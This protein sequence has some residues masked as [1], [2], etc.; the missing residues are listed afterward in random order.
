MRVRAARRTRAAIA[1]AAP[2]RAV[3]AV[4]VVIVVTTVTVVV[5]AGCP[6]SDVPTPAFAEAKGAYDKAMADTADT[7]YAGP[8]WDEVL[9]LLHAVPRTN[10]H[11]RHVAE[12][13]AGDIEDTRRRVGAELARSSAEADKLLDA[14]HLAP[15]PTPRAAPARAA[16]RAADCA[17]LCVT[18]ARA[19]LVDKG[20]TDDGKGVHCTG[21][22][23][24]AISACQQAQARCR[25]KCSPERAAC[26]QC[27]IDENDCFGD[28]DGCAG[29]GD[30]WRCPPAAADDAASCRERARTCRAATCH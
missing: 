13:L 28:L 7:S 4:T 14:P 21:E 6:R 1:V 19:C 20:C 2:V 10:A 24:A 29:A 25:Q 16:P 3:T 15:L 26:I 17:G 27:D 22:A 30:H 12:L 8:R 23:L 11:E 9:R 18:S 5:V